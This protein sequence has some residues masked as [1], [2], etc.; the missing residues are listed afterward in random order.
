MPVT[1]S[2]GEVIGAYQA[3]NKLGRLDESAFG[4]QDKNRLSLAAAYCGKLL[5]AYLLRV[6]SRMDQLTGLQNRHGFYEYYEN[7]ML[8]SKKTSKKGIIIGDIDFF[9]RVNDTYGHNAGDAVL[10][11]VA[12]MI[13]ECV[14]DIGEAF[15]WGGEE[16]VV[17]LPNSDLDQ[18]AALAEKIRTTIEQSHCIAEGHDIQITMSFGVKQIEDHRTLEENI[19]DADENLYEAKRSGRNRV[20][21]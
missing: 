15:R 21:K 3:I 1:N 7:C 12:K 18:T 5:E 16:M 13:R 14:G 20:V 8:Q 9:K 17:L 6:Q 4:E 2:C 19:R 11:H 10:Q